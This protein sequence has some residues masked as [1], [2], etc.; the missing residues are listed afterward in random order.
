M[1]QLDQPMKGLAA[2]AGAGST[3]GVAARAAGKEVAKPAV[4][5]RTTMALSARTGVREYIV[6][7][8]VRGRSVTG[9]SVVVRAS[10]RLG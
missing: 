3:V 5:A 4:T 7:L 8:L 2:T 6:G 10:R 9:G 1:L